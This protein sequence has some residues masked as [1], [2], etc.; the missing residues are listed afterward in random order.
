MKS[1]NIICFLISFLFFSCNILNTQDN[2][3]IEKLLKKNALKVT[4]STGLSGTLLMKEGD[5]MP[6]IPVGRNSSC[7]EHP[8]SRTINI[9]EYTGQHNIAGYGPLFDSVNSLLINQFTAD[10]DGFFQVTLDPGKYSVFIME[11][12]KFYANSFDGLG[13]IYPIDINADS[14]GI[15]ELI[16]DYASYK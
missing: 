4:I 10:Q 2:S 9:Y 6:T 1:I 8:I 3:D 5:C 15:I 16:I 12:D 13:G 14:V 7:K 11:N